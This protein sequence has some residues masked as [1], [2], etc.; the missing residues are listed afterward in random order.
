MT[1]SSPRLLRD[2]K[3]FYFYKEVHVK[4]YGFLKKLALISLEFK[5]IFLPRNLRIWETM[6]SDSR[7]HSGSLAAEGMV[8]GRGLLRYDVEH[9]R[10]F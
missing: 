10:N 2:L 9:H 3:I 4:F 5:R 8:R 6:R 7:T 1:L